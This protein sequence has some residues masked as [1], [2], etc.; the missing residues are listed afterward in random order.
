MNYLIF[1]KKKVTIRKFVTDFDCIV[2]NFNYVTY[3]FWILLLQNPD[4]SYIYSMWEA[5]ISLTT[6]T[7]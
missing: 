3:K 2:L 4:V 5:A 7:K 6:T 1:N